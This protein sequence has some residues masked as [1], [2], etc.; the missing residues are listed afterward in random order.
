MAAAIGVHYIP[1]DYCSA[2]SICAE[3][4]SR[5]LSSRIPDAAGASGLLLVRAAVVAAPMRRTSY[6]EHE[7]CGS[8]PRTRY[9]KL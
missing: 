9:R 2:A 4:E 5:P 3:T 1:L 8:Q 6:D 7:R